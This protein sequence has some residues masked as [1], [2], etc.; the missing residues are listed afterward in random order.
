M[1]PLQ[2][3]DIPQ[4]QAITV[5]S[6]DALPADWANLTSGTSWGRRWRATTRF[7]YIGGAGGPKQDSSRLCTDCYPQSSGTILDQTSNNASVSMFEGID[8][9]SISMFKRNDTASIG[10]CQKGET[11]SLRVV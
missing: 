2:S 6:D 3:S 10:I 5:G 11:A 4:A 7:F 1:R 8:T 9:G